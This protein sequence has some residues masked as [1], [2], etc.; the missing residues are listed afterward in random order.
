MSKLV[1]QPDQSEKIKRVSASCY[2]EP[3][4]EGMAEN[5]PSLAEEPDN[6][7]NME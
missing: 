1:C 6:M 5:N 2:L 7:N 3:L 4:N